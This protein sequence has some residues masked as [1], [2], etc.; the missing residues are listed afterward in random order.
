MIRLEHEGVAVEWVDLGEGMH[1]EFDPDDELDEPL[2]RF[3]VLRQRNDGEW[4]EVD[5]ASYCTLVSANT[6]PPMLWIGLATILGEVLDDV[7][8]GVSIKRICEVLSW[9]STDD[10]AN[11][12]PITAREST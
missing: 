9:M 3:D 4:E 5:A 1:G 7:I 10:L 12:H 11:D 2:L 8:A 6:V